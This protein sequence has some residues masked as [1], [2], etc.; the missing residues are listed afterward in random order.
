MKDDINHGDSHENKLLLDFLR[1]LRGVLLATRFDPEHRLVTLG[2]QWLEGDTPRHPRLAWEAIS[3]C[4]SH[5]LPIPAWVSDYLAEVAGRMGSADARDLRAVLPMILGFPPKPGPTSPLP[6]ETA[7]DRSMFAHLFA[8]RIE[9]GDNIPDAIDVAVLALDP[10][11][12][13]RDELTLLHWA[14]KHFGFQPTPRTPASWIRAMKRW[15]QREG[16]GHW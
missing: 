6:A 2:R 11:D 1:G 10:S 7:V 13:T 12:T 15:D 4:S 14:A 9:R 8:A 16:I 5:K 3:I